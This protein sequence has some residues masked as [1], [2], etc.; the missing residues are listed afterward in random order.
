MYWLVPELLKTPH[1]Y[2]HFRSDIYKSANLD[3]TLLT[4][5]ISTFPDHVS[6]LTLTGHHDGTY[7]NPKEGQQSLSDLRIDA[8]LP[9]LQSSLSVNKTLKEAPIHLYNK[10]ALPHKPQ[11][12]SCP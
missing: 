8:T 9:L 10:E 2:F 1:L 5:A 12:A 4:Q 7:E 11:I 6:A 3:F